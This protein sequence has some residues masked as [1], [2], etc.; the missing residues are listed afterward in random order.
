MEDESVLSQTW[1]RDSLSNRS[2]SSSSS[3]SVG[4][5]RR[6]SEQKKKKRMLPYGIISSPN[7]KPGGRNDEKGQEEKEEKKKSIVQENSLPKPQDSDKE[8]SLT[9]KN[10]RTSSFQR[11]KLLNYDDV[12]ARL[13][14]LRWR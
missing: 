5:P 3:S 8:A 14:A 9:R 13:A 10:E 4:S 2:L 6:D 12:V 11:P 1:T 7:T